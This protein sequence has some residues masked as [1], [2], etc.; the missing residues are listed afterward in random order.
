[1]RLLWLTKYS[2]S[3]FIEALS[4]RDCTAMPEE[5][6]EF[7]CSGSDKEEQGEQLHLI[8][9]LITIETCYG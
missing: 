2:D 4:K 6:E 3:A 7:F 1:M 9:I 5:V 8:K